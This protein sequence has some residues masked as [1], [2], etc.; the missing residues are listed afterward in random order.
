MLWSPG[1]VCSKRQSCVMRFRVWCA[2]R[3]QDWRCRCTP[4]NDWARIVTQFFERR[5]IEHADQQ[6]HERHNGSE[7]RNYREKVPQHGTQ[8]SGRSEDYTPTPWVQGGWPCK[9]FTLGRV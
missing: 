9:S 4:F 1:V 7:D 3:F 6:Y 8:H 2:M 5:V